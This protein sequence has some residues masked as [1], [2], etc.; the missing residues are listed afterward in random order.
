MNRISIKLA[1]Y[2]F[3]AVLI[4]EVFLMVYLHQN[5]LEERTDEEYARLVASGANHRDVLEDNY[6][7]TTIEHIA[8]MESDGD[9]EVVI[10]N[11]QG[12]IASSSDDH[13]LIEQSLKHV[14][15]LAANT[16]GIVIADWKSSP[17]IVSVHPYHIASGPSGY[18]VMYQSTEPIKL[19]VNKLNLHF[20]LA[21]VTSFVVLFIIYAILSK[22]LTRPLIRMKEATEKLSNGDFNVSLPVVGN[23]EL[24]ELSGSI[25]KL[26]TDL[27][28][29]KT[30]RNEF[31]ASIAH[32]LSTPLTYLIGYSTIA[33][34]QGLNEQERQH[35]LSIIVEES[36][37]MKDLVK[38]LLD[39]AKMDET[40]FTVSK[41]L[42]WTRPFFED[43]QRLVEPSFNMKNVQLAV[44]CDVD[45]QILADPL[46][47][48]Q[49]VLNL[50]D[51]AL[52]YSAEETEV[53]L[54]VYQK[55]EKTVIRVTDVGM[56]IPSEELAFIFE[57][58]YRVEKSRS[59]TF[60]G[61]GIGL[62]V[63]KELVEAHG[64]SIEVESTLGKGSRFTVTL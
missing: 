51:N 23:D 38:N 45:F 46:R 50:L 8:L 61:T 36:N 21:G 28:R 7:N 17:Y 20:G 37:R 12:I 14:R 47:L 60:G 22:L 5:I 2:F 19:L 25:Q 56:G 63:V 41:E 52:K 4:M 53:T 10:I 18:V 32:E 31:L 16:E 9:R 33:M 59:R 13:L 48:E 6:S 43:M 64:G 27:E 58:L 39:L 34:R 57:K 26:A 54:E 3:I 1:A 35:Y 40:T 49:I 30:E 55:K 29:L 44:R 62:A 42:F 15:N 11:R 24:G